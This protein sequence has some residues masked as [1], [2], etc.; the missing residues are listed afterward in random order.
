MNDF[1]PNRLIPH[2]DS[3][4]GGSLADSELGNINVQAGFA[5]CPETEMLKYA[6]ANTFLI[7]NQFACVVRDM[8]RAASPYSKM[9]VKHAIETMVSIYGR[10]RPTAHLQ[11]GLCLGILGLAREEMELHYQ[12]LTHRQRADA[13]SENALLLRAMMWQWVINQTHVKWLASSYPVESVRLQSEPDEEIKKLWPDAADTWY[14]DRSRGHEACSMLYGNR[15]KLTNSRGS[16]ATVPER[17]A[18]LTFL[19]NFPLNDS[20]NITAR[21]YPTEHEQEDAN[22]LREEESQ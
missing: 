11:H 17:R 16:L 21:V 9:L 13:R 20:L 19:H 5:Y 1:D 6:R 7:T 3:I 8:L 14:L 12:F 15:A 2:G 10:G 4:T 22:E 18:L